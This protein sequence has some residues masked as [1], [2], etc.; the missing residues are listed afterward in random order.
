[1]SC[2]SFAYCSRLHSHLSGEVF[3]AAIL[4]LQICA[5]QEAALLQLPH[6]CG[7]RDGY[8]RAIS[9]WITA[10][11]PFWQPWLRCEQYIKNGL[12]HIALPDNKQGAHKMVIIQNCEVCMVLCILYMF[13]ILAVNIYY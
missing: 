10:H 1:M 12:L 7:H 6:I 5:V 2:Y 9:T 8:E 11:V 3:H 13:N 4:F